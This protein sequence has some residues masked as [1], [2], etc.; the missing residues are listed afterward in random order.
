[1]M[2]MMTGLTVTNLEEGKI[3]LQRDVD[4]NDS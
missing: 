3:D 2:I 1:M 4:E